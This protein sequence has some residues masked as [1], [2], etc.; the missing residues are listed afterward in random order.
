MCGYPDELLGLATGY[1]RDARHEQ[2]NAPS[3]QTGLV[4]HF[5]KLWSCTPK[6]Q[7]GGTRMPKEF[8][9]ASVS[10]LVVCVVKG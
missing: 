10:C 6:T 8:I 2:W 5:A 4:G 1:L 9:T 3:H 7:R